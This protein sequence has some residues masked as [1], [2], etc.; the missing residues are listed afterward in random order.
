MTI[1]EDRYTEK[2]LVGAMAQSAKGLTCKSE[3]LGLNARTLVK[4]A[5]CCLFLQFRSLAGRG[6]WTLASP[7]SLAYLVSL[8][9][10]EDTVSK[11]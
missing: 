10:E 11:K 6:G 5:G 8:R 2:Q 3:S 1:F 4:K 9:P 7:A